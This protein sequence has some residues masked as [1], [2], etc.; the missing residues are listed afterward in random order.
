MKTDRC[1]YLKELLQPSISIYYSRDYML[2]VD[3][4]KKHGEKLE[5]LLIAKSDLCVANSTY[6]SDYCKQYN[7]LFYAL[8]NLSEKNLL[9]IKKTSVSVL[10][11]AWNPSEKRL[12][13][14]DG[15]PAGPPPPG[16][17]IR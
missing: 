17:S 15:A 10:S 2:A 5:P 8:L 12:E 7:S 9:S 16:R 13:E 4:W 11:E 6:L 14:E 1:F 3:Y